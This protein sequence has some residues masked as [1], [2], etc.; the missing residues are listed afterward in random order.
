MKAEFDFDGERLRLYIKVEDRCEV[1]MAKVIEK[2]NRAT[3]SLVKPRQDYGYSTRDE[4]PKGIE[5]ILR[6]APKCLQ[7]G[8]W[9]ERGCDSSYECKQQP[10]QAIPGG[11]EHG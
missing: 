6:E 8:T 3:V 4:D 11:V 7:S 10:V 2:Y 5:V 9:C 1:A